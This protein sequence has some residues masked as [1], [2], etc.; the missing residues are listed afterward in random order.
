MI[1]ERI[2]EMLDLNRVEIVYRL[3]S[4][5]HYCMKTVVTRCPRFMPLCHRHRVLK[6]M[7]A[8]PYVGMYDMIHHRWLVLRWDDIVEYKI[9]FSTKNFNHHVEK[10]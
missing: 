7:A 3:L 6:P 4:S 1:R 2:E 5:K 10:Q 8:T 9:V